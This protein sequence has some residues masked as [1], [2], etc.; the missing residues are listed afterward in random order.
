MKKLLIISVI[1]VALGV[2]GCGGSSSSSGGGSADFDDCGVSRNAASTAVV[3]GD[4]DQNVMVLESD[5]IT[6]R[7]SDGNGIVMYYA[8]GYPTKAILN[9]TAGDAVDV[10]LFSNWDTT[11]NTVDVA[12]VL[13]DGTISISRTIE[14]DSAVMAQLVSVNASVSLEMGKFFGFDDATV[15]AAWE[16]AGTAFSAAMCGAAIGTAAA[17]AGVGLPGV[18]LACASTVVYLATEFDL[19]GE[20]NSVIAASGT[21][22]TGLDILDCAGGDP[23]ACAGAAFD[24]GNAMIE[25]AS[26]E[27][28][29][30]E[31]EVNLADGALE[32]GYG[33]VKVTLTWDTTGD[34]DLHVIDPDSE[35]IYW[36]HTTSASGGIL[37]V[38]DTDGYGPENIY[39]PSGGAPSGTY[40]WFVKYYS[41]SGS[42]TWNVLTVINDTFTQYSGTLT[43][44]GGSAGE[45]STHL[46]FAY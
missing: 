24:I 27:E 16:F 2:A 37:D 12:F 34:L 3:V 42:A 20:D 13:S 46:T 39:W 30:I 31:D 44:S 5:T 36:A 38:D 21:V 32:S 15:G 4:T 7:A 43:T 41:G 10:I 28:A 14:V 22:L 45:E 23:T 19:V 11:N 1:V 40:T 29:N 33:S 8:D 25:Y 26:S 18:A 9:N 17:S 6:F 35:E